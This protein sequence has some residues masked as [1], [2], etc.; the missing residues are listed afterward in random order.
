MELEFL[1]RLSKKPQLPNFIKMRPVAAEFFHADRRT[2]KIKLIVAFRNF[3]NKPK[4]NFKYAGNP[5]CWQQATS[6][7]L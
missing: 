4:N 2:G 7:R 5:F 6:V 1:A 3:S